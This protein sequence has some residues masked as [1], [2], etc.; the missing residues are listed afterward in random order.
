MLAILVFSAKSVKFLKS[1]NY[2]INNLHFFTFPRHVFETSLKIN[3]IM[4]IMD[5]NNNCTSA[6]STLHQVRKLYQFLY[7]LIVKL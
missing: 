2:R 7:M 4:V 5:L 3:K 1:E 6:W